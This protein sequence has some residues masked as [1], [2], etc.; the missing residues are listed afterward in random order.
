MASEQPHTTAVDQ[1]DL[2]AYISGTFWNTSW[3]EITV[4]LATF[5]TIPFCQ[6]TIPN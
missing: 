6:D 4:S 1:W 5:I 3:H 2:S